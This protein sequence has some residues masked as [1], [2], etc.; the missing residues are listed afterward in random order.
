MG[1]F[2]FALALMFAA[3]VLTGILA[4]AYTK[5]KDIGELFKAIKRSVDG[6]HSLSR[7]VIQK[8]DL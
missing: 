1:K 4:Y 2:I 3:G 6:D 7:E 5:K 8:Y